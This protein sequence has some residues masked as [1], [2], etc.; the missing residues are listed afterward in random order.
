MNASTWVLA[1]ACVQVH[2]LPSACNK[3]CHRA[4]A[5]VY[6]DFAG[7][8]MSVYACLPMHICEDW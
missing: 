2:T 8:R 1:Y 6:L 4:Y 5:H 7:L 3:K